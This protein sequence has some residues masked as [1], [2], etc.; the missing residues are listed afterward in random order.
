MR[1]RFL[2]W[3][4]MYR[5]CTG[6]V[7]STI[8]PTFRDP[9]ASADEVRTA[10]TGVGMGDAVRIALAAAAAISLLRWRATLV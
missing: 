3:L 9:A 4:M 7:V 5:E 1:W 10:V 8:D 2:A 6:I